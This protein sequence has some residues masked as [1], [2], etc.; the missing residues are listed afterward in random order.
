MTKK[1]EEEKSIAL[2]IAIKEIEKTYGNII[3][4]NNIDHQMKGVETVST[5]IISLDNILGRGG[6]AK[7]RMVEIL[8]LP[9]T[10][11][12]T[13]AL[14]IIAEI[15]KNGGRCLF[16]DSEHALDIELARNMGV[17]LDKLLI[18]QVDYGEQGFDIAETFIKSGEISCVVI[19][20]IANL[21]PKAE[22]EGD[23]SDEHMGRRA[24]L[25][26]KAMTRLTPLVSKT[27]TILILINQIYM[28]MSPYGQRELAMGGNKIKYAVSYKVNVRK[29]ETLTSPEGD[30]YGHSIKVTAIKNKL[31]APFKST[32]LDL[33]Y[34]IGIDKI[35][36][37]IE[38][39]VDLAIIE[40]GGSWYE[41]NGTKY[42]G[43][44]NLKEFI[45]SDN[46]VDDLKN[47]IMALMKD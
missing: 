45:K 28:N 18:T 13:L 29:A 11:K 25:I 32:E 37:L 43:L 44:N 26:S 1:K 39:A 12:T 2:E 41:Y 8:G 23:I 34:G 16:I 6:I 5:G 14:H 46:N 36:D 30:I 24:K 17:N 40:K 20:S 35:K 22:L 10:G 3:F 21:I 15:Q 7:G 47:K 33:I 38:A 27:N 31:S 19:D 42:Q 9:Y 4:G